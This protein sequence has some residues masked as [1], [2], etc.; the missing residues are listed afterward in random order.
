MEKKFAGVDHFH[1]VVNG[2]IYEKMRTKMIGEDYISG[3][4]WNLVFFFYYHF[5]QMEP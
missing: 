4:C 3:V 1:D 2:D 5:K